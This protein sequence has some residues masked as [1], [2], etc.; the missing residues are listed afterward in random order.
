[1][2]SSLEEK[3]D[4]MLPYLRQQLG[5]S[6]LG[7]LDGACYFQQGLPRM[8][9]SEIGSL[10]SHSEVSRLQVKTAD[11][12]S[13]QGIFGFNENDITNYIETMHGTHLRRGWG[14]IRKGTL[15]I[16]LISFV[17]RKEKVDFSQ[18]PATWESPVHIRIDSRNSFEEVTKELGIDPKCIFLKLTDVISAWERS[19]NDRLKEVSG[20]SDQ[21]RE[22]G[23]SLIRRD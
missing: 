6:T 8:K 18:N 5:R 20:L 19:V 16:I 15:V 4:R 13:T 11:V 10:T 7:T 3:L 2:N 23:L 12:L 17:R 22:I 21:F 1:M 14:I 9:P